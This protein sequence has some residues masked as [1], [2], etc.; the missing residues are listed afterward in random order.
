LTDAQRQKL[1]LGG[2]EKIGTLEDP[3]FAKAV[4]LLGKQAAQNPNTIKKN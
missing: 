3:Q 1:W 4:E 2:R